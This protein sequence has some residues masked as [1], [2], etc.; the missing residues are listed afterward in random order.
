MSYFPSNLGTQGTLLLA[1]V[2][3]SSLLLA[4]CSVF[5]AEEQAPLQLTV[6]V[7]SYRKGGWAQV[8]S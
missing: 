3:L 8:N 1:L 7:L 2:K 6:S 4:Q 5:W